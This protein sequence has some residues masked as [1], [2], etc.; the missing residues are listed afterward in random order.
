LDKDG[1][2]V[3]GDA[4]CWYHPT[5]I[6]RVMPGA[7]VHKTKV[8][9]K[10]ELRSSGQ[11]LQGEVTDSEEDSDFEDPADFDEWTPGNCGQDDVTSLREHASTLRESASL[12]QSLMPDARSDPNSSSADLARE[13][14]ESV[15]ITVGHVEGLMEALL[16][17]EDDDAATAAVTEALA[18]I[19]LAHSCQ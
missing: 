6:A 10:S 16:L 9:L 11:R 8:S 5:E 14:Q 3:F 15:R 13:L 17:R 19:D 18:A 4:D 1:S 2:V 12:L 7:Y